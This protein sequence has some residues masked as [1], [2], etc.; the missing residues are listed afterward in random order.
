MK[1]T[2]SSM[3]PGVTFVFKNNGNS[4]GPEPLFGRTHGGLPDSTFQYR[5]SGH[6]PVI[7]FVQPN[8][9]A[10]FL[11]LLLISSH[12]NECS[13][14]SSSSCSF[15]NHNHDSWQVM[16]FLHLWIIS[17]CPTTCFMVSAVFRKFLLHDAACN[18]SGESDKV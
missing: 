9:R 13:F 11:C 14:H 10:L 2:R 6:A 7:Q 18:S 12:L 3:H 16:V 1:F 15:N 17:L 4:F 8:P 5:Y